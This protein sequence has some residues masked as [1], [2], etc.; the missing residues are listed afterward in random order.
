MSY[1]GVQQA[2][3]SGMDAFGYE[4][5]AVFGTATSRMEELV[6]C[7]NKGDVRQCA[8][9]GQAFV[10]GVQPR[11]QPDGGRGWHPELDAQTGIA[12]AFSLAPGGSS[13]AGLLGT[14]GGKQ[15]GVTVLV[16]DMEYGTSLDGFVF[17]ESNS[18][19]CFGSDFDANETG[20]YRS[21]IGRGALMPLLTLDNATA[22]T[23]AFPDTV[24]V[25]RPG[26]ASRPHG[27]GSSPKRRTTAVS[28]LLMTDH[29]EAWQ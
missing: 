22:T 12:D 2:I 19:I 11:I 25:E 18:S 4:P 8:T 13:L 29:Q 6:R 24:D 21:S 7:G 15:H 5:F 14:S 23:P 9:D 28:Q 17:I 10:E 20:G 27:Q 16:L 1:R 26:R 3:R